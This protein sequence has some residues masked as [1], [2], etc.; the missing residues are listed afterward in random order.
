MISAVP[1]LILQGEKTK[2][3]H[4]DKSIVSNLSSQYIPNA[5]STKPSIDF[6]GF[7]F[8]GSS[9]T[10]RD[11]TI[12]KYYHR[13]YR[14][15][16]TIT[17]NGGVLPS[18]KRISCRRLYENYSF[19]GTSAYQQRHQKSNSSVNHNKI[20]RGNFLDYVIR[21]KKQFPNDPIDRSTKRHMQKIQKYL[22]DN[23]QMKEDE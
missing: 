11:K 20:H 1:N 15:A 21:A 14:K 23:M 22:C 10:I 13:L 19:K 12:S 4:L 18:G 6:L 3:F 8:D 16:K 5:Q 17:D 2:I 9:I 7:S